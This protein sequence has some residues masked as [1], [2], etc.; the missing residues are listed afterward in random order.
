LRIFLLVLTVLG[1]LA[2]I[3]LPLFL[4]SGCVAKYQFANG[5]SVSVGI[6]GAETREAFEGWRK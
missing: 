2:M 6:S 5:S 1:V 4:L 3:A